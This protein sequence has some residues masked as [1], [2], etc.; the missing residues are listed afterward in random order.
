M[1]EPL[2]EELRAMKDYDPANQGTWLIR[3]RDRIIAEL[4]RLRAL[5][6]KYE[7]RLQIDHCYRLADADKRTGDVDND[8]IYE[9]VPPGER[10]TFPDRIECLEA[11]EALRN[12]DLG[13]LRAEVERLQRCQNSV[14]DSLQRS[15]DEVERLKA[16]L[17][18][19]IWVLE[20]GG[21]PSIDRLAALLAA[22]GGDD[23]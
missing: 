1:S 2:T 4:D 21:Y 23:E 11:A 10:A 20:S 5:V 8:L 22:K 12:L 15:K 18:G 3:N 19:A 16:G 17:R 9:K 14:V 13:R 6:Q 7:E